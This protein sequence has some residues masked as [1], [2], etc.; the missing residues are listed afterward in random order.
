MFIK[1]L[2]KKIYKRNLI[3]KFLSK[4]LF[5]FLIGFLFSFIAFPSKAQYSPTQIKIALIVHFIEHTTF[6]SEAFKSPK[7]MIQIGILG[8]DPFGDELESFLMHYKINGRGLRV[9]RKKNASDLWGCQVIYISKSEQNKLTDIL[10]YFRRYPTLTIGDNLKGFIE[11]CG[12]INFV[13]VG[14]K[15]YRFELNIEAAQKSN[16]GLD[17][18]LFRMAKRI[19]ACP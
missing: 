18:G 6:P 10:D 7:E 17:V 15:P 4:A 12:I 11:Q 19:V 8:D 5:I 2:S 16:L 3:S 1:L 9:R 13:T 14:D